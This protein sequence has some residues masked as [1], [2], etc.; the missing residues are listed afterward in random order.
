MNHPDL[1]PPADADAWDEAATHAAVNQLTAARDLAAKWSATVTA[2]LGV[3]GSVAIVGGTSELSDIRWQWL[4]IVL[5]VLT[6]AAG[7]IAGWSI[8]QGALAAQGSDPV[9][10]LSFDG[11]QLRQLVYDETPDTLRHL[12]SSRLAGFIAAGLVFGVGATSLICATIP[13]AQQKQDFVVVDHGRVLCGPMT[14]SSGTVSAIGGVQLSTATTAT[15]VD[16]C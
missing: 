15:P 4:R 8:Y 12:K 7:F 14:I 2:L 3:F 10:H 13:D 5:L 9:R 16:S 6:L 1:P 11:D